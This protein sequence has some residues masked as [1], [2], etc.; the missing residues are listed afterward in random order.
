M[1][2]MT[3]SGSISNSEKNRLKSKYGSWALVTGA[4]SGIGQELAERIAES[5]LNIALSARRK[6]VLVEMATRL[7]VQYGVQVEVIEADLNQQSEVIQVLHVTAHLDIGLFVA[8]AGFGTS[9]HFTDSDLV[10]ELSMLQVN[11]T[12]LMTMTHYFCQKFKARGRGGIILMSS[13]V[14]FQGTPNAAHYAA[15]KAYVQ[16]LAEAIAVEIKPYGVDVLA[17]APGP[18]RSGFESRADMRMANSLTPQQVGMPIL[19]ALGRQQTVYPGSLTKILI[20]ALSTAPRW[21]RV[22]IM[23]KVMGGMT[24]HQRK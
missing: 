8:S 2:N 20:A 14:G 7:S 1:N 10:E 16:S 21:I 18:V 19:K 23:D 12:A 22:R 11:C 4:S 9:G 24:A 3:K 17:A 6:D 13:I 5:G 15:T